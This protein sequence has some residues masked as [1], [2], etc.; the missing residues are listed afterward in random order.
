MPNVISKMKKDDFLN[1]IGETVIRA[2]YLYNSCE[3]DYLEN[4]FKSYGFIPEDMMLRYTQDME[5]YSADWANY[6]RH[7]K[8]Y[9]AA[10]YVNT[11]KTKIA[12]L[13][14]KRNPEENGVAKSNKARNAADQNTKQRNKTTNK[15]QIKKF[16]KAGINI[17]GTT[18]FDQMLK[19]NKAKY[20]IRLNEKMR[21]QDKFRKDKKM[22]QHKQN[23][24]V[25]INKELRNIDFSDLTL[26]TSGLN[27]K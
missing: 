8:A 14:K 13:Q 21:K 19:M 22:A 6:D 27:R 7:D 26:A 20:K 12:K 17:K 4:T 10:V 1:I 2:F 5:D 11:K 9:W 25:M 15:L 3:A 24:A 23:K 16:K 18:P